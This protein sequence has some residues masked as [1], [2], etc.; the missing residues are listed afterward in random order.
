LLKA[1]SE[2]GVNPK[3]LRVDGG[4]VTNSWVC[5][6]LA[7][8]L[9]VT[10]ERPKVMETTAL[11]VAYLAGLQVGIYQSTDE[12]ASMNQIDSRFEPQM[13]ATKREKLLKGWASAIQSTL[14]FKA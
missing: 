4:M 6:F 7:G 5:Q 2:D 8:V 3:K 11:G 9:D 12:L 10:V 13:Q 14:G 1:M